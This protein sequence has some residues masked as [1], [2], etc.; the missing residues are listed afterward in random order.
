MGLYRYGFNGFIWLNGNLDTEPRR[1]LCEKFLTFSHRNLVISLN[2]IE[3]S[4]DTP[5]YDIYRPMNTIINGFGG[6]R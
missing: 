6:I 3:M 4:Q 5:F 1:P 2:D